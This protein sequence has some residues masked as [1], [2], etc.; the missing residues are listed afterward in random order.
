MLKLLK[1]KSGIVKR[2]LVTVDVALEGTLDREAEVLSLNLG[3]LGELN[4]DVGQVKKSDLLVEDLGED[5]DTDVELAGL[6]ELDV[7][8]AELLISS[9][10]QHDLGKDLVGERAGHD[11]GRVASGAS[12]VDETALSKEDDVTAVLH[13]VAVDLGLDVLDGLGVGLQPGNIDFDIEVT[14]V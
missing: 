2:N 4:V 10:V 3:E 5:V 9:L 13:E 1:L 14:D 7:L 12:Q 6:A 8:V 11:E